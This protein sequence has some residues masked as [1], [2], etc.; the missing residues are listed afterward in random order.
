MKTPRT[1]NFEINQ[2]ILETISKLLTTANNMLAD[3]GGG[4]RKVAGRTHGTGIRRRRTTNAVTRRRV[5]AIRRRAK[6]NKVMPIHHAG[7]A[8][9]VAA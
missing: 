3:I 1:T 8:R 2:P 7:T 6:T 9:K 4:T 5:A